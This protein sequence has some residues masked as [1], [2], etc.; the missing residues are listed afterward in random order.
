VALSTD[1]EAV[2]AAARRR[3]TMYGRLP[4]YARMF[5]DAGYP[6]RA[7]GTLPDALLDALV[8]AGDAP[9]VA[10]RLA[11]IQ[12]Q[13]LDELLVMLVPVADADAE[14]VALLR[15]LRDGA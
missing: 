5:A 11:E 13:G 1:G 8:V 12:A 3:L 15:V 4:F 7:D 2:H 6:P 9:R 10:A 14:E